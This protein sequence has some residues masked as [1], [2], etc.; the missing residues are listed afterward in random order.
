MLVTKVRRLA[1]IRQV[2]V[3]GAGVRRKPIPKY[4][5]VH[6]NREIVKE[7]AK[8][9]LLAH[10]RNQTAQ[11]LDFPHLGRPKMGLVRASVE[12]R[13]GND[14]INEERLTRRSTSS[15]SRFDDVADLRG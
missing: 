12:R 10:L 1:A 15:R 7:A 14:L 3:G 8:R 4:G 2:V 13:D 6:H 11:L 9:M 5:F